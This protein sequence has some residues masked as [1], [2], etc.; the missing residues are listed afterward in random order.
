MVN[1]PLAR[2]V[3]LLATYLRPQS[4]KVTLLGLCLLAGIGLQL[5]NPQI[6]R[7]FIDSA[8]AGQAT[9]TLVRLAL[10]FIGVAIGQ[11]VIAVLARYTGERI[12]WQ[13]TNALRRDLALH[14]L[15][16][17]MGFHN[18]HTPGALI[19]RIDGDVSLLATFFSTV[20][21]T[22]LSN[23]LLLVGVLLLLLREEWRVGLSLALIAGLGLVLMMRVRALATPHWIAGRKATAD[24]A[25]FVEERLAGTADVR[26]SGATAYTMHRFHALIQSLYGAYRKAIV[27][28]NAVVGTGRLVT[29]LGTV[30]ALGLSAWLYRQGDMTLGTVYLVYAYAGMLWLPLRHITEQI[31]ELQKAEASIERVEDLFHT[32]IRVVDG[33]GATFPR[34]PLSLAFEDVGFGY[35]GDKA[36]VRDIS[37]SL[38]PG[39]R[40]GLLG[41]TG[42][43]KTTLTRL[44]FRLYDPDAG[45]IRL[46]GVDIRAARLD[47][48]RERI[49]MV[50]QEVQLFRASVRD[51]LTFFD[52]TIPDERI[53][54][55]IETLGL[56]EWYTSLPDGL[57]TL[58]G[59][60]GRG[61]SA[62]EGQLLAFT[63]V[64]LKDPGLV[65]LD[66]ASSRL[67][68]ATERLLGQAV[69]RLLA[70]RTA[71]IIAHRLGTVR[72]VD[73][74]M[75]VEGGRII[76]HGRREELAATPASRFAQL[77]HA[78]LELTT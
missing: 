73:E 14:A 49:G 40:L 23:L 61:L 56:G 54:D 12:A 19:E 58:L 4:L 29:A 47:E 34:G 33:P 60:G 7:S 17:D 32:P 36:V 25:G 20:V 68:P 77:L 9:I 57:D 3:R 11:Q 37:F 76:E 52:P 71:I 44:L 74:I 78:G 53:L 62:G 35:G 39:R 8:R 65:V 27:L 43:G 50:T 24:F 2:Y 16:L 70:G 22:V 15:H 64:F 48:L 41:R 55:A 42:S 63:R 69:E 51:N 6:L 5:A 26:A 10:L 75:I 31:A 28:G 66:E 67:D 38:V 18:T 21:L 13:A 59:V 72:H 46:G 30:T 45:T 1:I